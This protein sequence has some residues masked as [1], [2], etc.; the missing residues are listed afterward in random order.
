MGYRR[1]K[2]SS[3]AKPGDRQRA[4]ALEYNPEK[5]RAPRLIASG[6][7]KVAE[8]IIALAKDHNVPIYEDPLLAAALATVNLEEEIPPELYLVVAEILAY[9]YRISGRSKTGTR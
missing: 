3:G 5:D 4:A 9:I 1:F 7:G 2:I 8:K 6:E